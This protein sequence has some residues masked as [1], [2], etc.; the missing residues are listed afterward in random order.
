MFEK[1]LANLDLDEASTSFHVDVDCLE[2]T[3]GNMELYSDE[4]NTNQ[5]WRDTGLPN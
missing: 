4:L 5:P 1:I 2:C 3:G